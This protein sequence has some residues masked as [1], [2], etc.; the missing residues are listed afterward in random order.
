MVELEQL[1]EHRFYRLKAVWEN[2]CPKC[3][4]LLKLHMIHNSINLICLSCRTQVE[5]PRVCTY[6]GKSHLYDDLTCDECEKIVINITVFVVTIDEC[7][8]AI[9]KINR[10]YKVGKLSEIQWET[11][12]ALNK[13]ERDRCQKELEKIKE[14]IILPQST[15]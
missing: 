12:L 15:S 13:E 1:V 4:S 9:K 2:S 6:C 14:S 7:E 10:Q 5:V 11:A 3:N 8:K